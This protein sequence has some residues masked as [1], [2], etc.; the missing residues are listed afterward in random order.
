[1][2]Q[3]TPIAWL[4]ASNSVSKIS[5]WS[6]IFAI[7][8]GTHPFSFLRC[9]PLPCCRSSNTRPQRRLTAI[10][11]LS[12]SLYR[13]YVIAV[14]AQRYRIAPHRRCHP[15]KKPHS[16]LRW[17]LE[18]IEPCPLHTQFS[19]FSTVAEYLLDSCFICLSEWENTLNFDSTYFR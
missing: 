3:G 18:C 16:D 1:M 7:T 14:I 12:H 8:E 10:P 19:P 6:R 5:Y 13:V 11:T 2:G 17:I 15:N 4:R 9:H